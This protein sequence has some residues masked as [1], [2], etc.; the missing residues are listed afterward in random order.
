MKKK[1]SN[2][3]VPFISFNNCNSEWFCSSDKIQD[4]EVSDTISC[5]TGEG[6]DRITLM[7]MIDNGADVRYVCT[8]NI[9]DYYEMFSNAKEFNQDIGKWKVSNVKYMQSMFYGA[10][11]FNQDLN[12]WDV[13]NAKG[14]NGVFY[15]AESFN[16]NI[17]DWK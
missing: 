3:N 10:L 13:S 12:N 6:V 2:I 7:T 4:A 9:T 1:I 16:G 11:S 14:F 17:K 15:E 5:A 8:T